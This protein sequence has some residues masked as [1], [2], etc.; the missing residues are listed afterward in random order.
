MRKPISYKEFV[1]LVALLMSL[2][3][4]CIDTM[5]PAL[6]IIGNDLHVN[7]PNDVQLI[8]STVFLGIA[9]GMVFYGPLSDSFGRKPALYVGLFLFIVGCL[10]SVMAASL[11]MMLLGRFIQ[12]LGA[13]SPRVV[14]M[15]LVRDKFEGRTMAQVMSFSMTLFIFV[16][17]IA[18][19]LGQGILAFFTWHAIFV[20]FI[21]FA[22]FILV[23]FGVRME[24][25]LL[26]HK[27][28]SFRVAVIIAGAKETLNHPVVFGYTLILSIVLGIF[29][30]FLSSVQQVLGE[31]YATGEDFPFYF[32]TLALSLGL[33]SFVNG[34]IVMRFGARRLGR[35]GM[36]VMIVLA[37]LFLP[38]V[39]MY[40]GVPSL[41][42]VMMYFMG[43][44]FSIGML[45]G[46][47]NA[48]S[49]EPLGHIAG[50]GSATIGAV[51]TLF[52]LPIGIFIGQMYSGTVLPL[53]WAF[54]IAGLTSFFLMGRIEA[55]R[56]L[57]V[58]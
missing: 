50:I 5:L 6:G 27:R 51:S 45:F 46:N 15:A 31:L 20:F 8:I 47:L 23:W 10:I 34:K 28:R 1:V 32:A 18:P 43:T 41:W 21:F 11:E 55:K 13:A 14:N 52:S 4:L 16:P 25:T 29:I 9:L 53:V 49:M 44:F 39:Y 57:H 42:M 3:A 2:T 37:T 7:H 30:G 48:I 24:E 35:T 54:F 19:L 22:L 33:S 40:A 26:P 12:G 36:M 56:S 38:I 58:K 17:A